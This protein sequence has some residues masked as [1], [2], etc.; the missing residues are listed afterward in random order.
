LGAGR[1]YE[2]AAAGH[3]DNNS[4][5][6]FL[7]TLL[8]IVS[9]F[10]S[11]LSGAETNLL[12]GVSRIVFLG[13]SIT[14]GGQFVDDVE[15][16]LVSRYLERRFEVLNLGLPSETVSGLSEPGHAGGKFPRPDLHERLGRA[17]EQTKPDLVIACYG[18]ND[19]IYYP[20]G[21]DRF[22]KFQDGVRRLHERVTATG[23]KILHV[24]PPVFDPVPIMARTLPAGLTEYRSP[25]EG[26]NE[27]LD[28]YSEWLLAQHAAGWAVV[29]AH[30]PMNRF[31]AEQRTMNPGFRLA[32]DG[33]HPDDTGHWLIASAILPALGAPGAVSQLE[34]VQAMLS[35]HPRGA[36]LLKLIQQRQRVLKDAWLTQTGH[37]RPGMNKGLPLAEAQRQADDLEIKIRALAAPFSGKRS[38]W[39]GFDRFDFSIDGRT[40][41]VIAPMTALPGRQWAWKGEFLDAFPATEIALLRRGIYLVYL[42]DPDML[43]CADA[44]EHWN[45]AYQELTSKHGLARKPALIGLSRGG[46]YCYNWAASNPDKVACIYGDAPVCDFKSWPGGRGKGKGSP[47][48]WQLVIERYHFADE[49]AALAY[50]RNPVDNLAPLAAAKVP[51]IHVYGDADD[52]VPWDENTGVLAERYR[53]LGGQITLISK[54]G[55]GHHPHGLPDPTPVVD[56]IITNTLAANAAR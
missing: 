25:Y 24:T 39:N 55:V 47:R 52:V 33:V 40:V 50:A 44:V 5:M 16:F 49:A 37:Q 3:F 30:G 29:D 19:G 23:A 42:S 8:L 34:S 38:S 9:T 22:Q 2:L 11:S 6:R 51:L 15:A 7:I 56:F 1:Y 21:D 27:V 13:D 18:M 36:E 53:K 35:A 14:Y 26:Y 54:P 4:A 43:G 45:A 17:L 12:D 10:A 48:D 46:L 28:H 32:G 20:P 41:S 31:L